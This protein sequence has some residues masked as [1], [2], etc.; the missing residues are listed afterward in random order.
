MNLNI[1][2]GY[3]LQYIWVA[4]FVKYCN[5]KICKIFNL[6]FF[7]EYVNAVKFFE[8]IYNFYISL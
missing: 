8:S 1:A 7:V 6:Y 3:L 2:Y 5:N 4:K